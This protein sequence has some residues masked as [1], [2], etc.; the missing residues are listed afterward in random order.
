MTRLA[1]PDR[2]LS[3]FNDQ[4]D[5]LE[6]QISLLSDPEAETPDPARLAVL[7]DEL[8][9]IERRISSYKSDGS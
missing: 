8:S 3:A 1:R 7:R 6:I 2:T 4:R 5:H 9:S